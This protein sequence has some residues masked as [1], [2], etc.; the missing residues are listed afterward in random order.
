VARRRN[1]RHGARRLR[2]E[3]DM[4]PARWELVQSLFH[5]VADLSPTARDEFLK[6]A[7]GDDGPLIDTLV[8]MLEQDRHR[9]S[10]L[11]RDLACA[12]E[13]MVGSAETSAIAG[14]SFGP[15]RLVR[16]LGEGGAGI[17]YLGVRDDLGSIAAIKILGDAWLSPGRR[18]R[19]ASEQRILA[20]LNHPC[21]ARLYDADTLPDGTPWFAM[22]Y[23]EGIPLTDYCRA[24][25]ASLAERLQLFLDMCDAVQYA[26]RQMIVHRDL[27]PSNILVTP[28]GG[29][30]LLDFGIAKQL[31]IF[32]PTVTGLRLMTPAYAAPEQVAGGPTGVQTDVYALGAI[33]YEL[34]ADRPPFDLSNCTP[35]D[36]ERIVVS[37]GPPVRVSLAAAESVQPGAGYHAWADLDTLC[38]T[39]MHKDLQRRYGS[40]EALRRDV[41][42][43]LRCEPL[44][45]RPDSV[46]YRTRK[47]VRRNRRRLAATAAVFALLVS[48]VVFY[49]VRL[50]IARNAAVAET[51]RT[52]RI[53]RFMLQ[54]FDGGDK[55]A[56]P[57]D[58]L[59]VVTL[60]DRGYAEARLLDRDPLVQ[61][62]LY[63]T[64]GG[65]Y[66]KLGKFERADLLLQSSLEVR[67]SREG[68]G[69]VDVVNS[70]VALAL[71][72]SDQGRFDEAERFARTALETARANV[73]ATDPVIARATTALG[74][75]LEQRGAYDQAIPVLEDAA[76]MQSNAGVDRAEQAATLLE[77]ANTHFYAGHYDVSQS[78]NR[79]VLSTHRELHGD[80]HPLVAEGLINLGAIEH[81]RGRYSEAER[82]YRQALD[83][84]QAWYGKDS[85]KTASNLT[86][87]GRSLVF[88][89]RYDEAR[90]L[91]GRALAIQEQVL[92]V[93]HPRVASALNDL[94]NVA[95]KENAPDEAEA[96][97]RRIG[98]IYRSVYGEKHYLVAVA[99]SNLAG[100]FMARHDYRT[101]EQMYRD[102]VGRFS[103][104]QSPH[105][106]NTGIAR[107]KLGRSLLQQQ[108]YSEAETETFAGYGIVSKQAAPTVSWLRSA[109]EDLVSIYD[110]RHE[111]KK[112]EMMRAEAASYAP[113]PVVAPAPTK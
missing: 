11:D 69:A 30:K 9:A 26:H 71:L 56:G 67:R 63:Q 86:M 72:R 87:L 4:D 62:D 31:D 8:K 15:Y 20:Q 94:G 75:I 64:L 10:V 22:E 66:Q 52:E 3:A 107:I 89:N 77:L 97:F 78:L 96:Y 36:A 73:R 88:E 16:V 38:L 103:D 113:Q 98:V 19:F 44:E 90:E 13:T 5:Q 91:L 28:A 102:A 17:V 112:A 7:C 27:K 65:I 42:H 23:V 39:A 54:L 84:N 74:G 41:V 49:T 32:D 40:I 2:I 93:A 83:I 106:L 18:D 58:D 108:R 110:A 101:A 14:Q 104:A 60:V 95:M 85:H 55:D 99:V 29:V 48:I 46:G 92:G 50:A 53:Q 57:A 37:G 6:N 33:L 82:F 35:S 25:A 105:H 61:A 81:E 80:R 47:F 45:A 12:A 70:L 34:L 111:W 51:S 68:A 21:I 43:Y 76:R 59:R 109:R 100:V 79:R 24:H 1:R